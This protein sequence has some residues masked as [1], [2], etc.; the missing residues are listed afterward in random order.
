MARLLCLTDLPS[1]AWT[2]QLEW[3]RLLLLFDLAL[4]SWLT[5]LRVLGAPQS[6]T[7]LTRHL[8]SPR[9]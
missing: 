4:P 7:S 8:L 6:S 1:T 3:R 2:L 9:C 5:R